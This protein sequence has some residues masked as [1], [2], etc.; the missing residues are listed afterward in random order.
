M[1]MYLDK[2]LLGSLFDVNLDIGTVYKLRAD[3]TSFPA[4][5]RAVRVLCFCALGEIFNLSHD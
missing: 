2:D 5:E 4:N 3:I 1:S